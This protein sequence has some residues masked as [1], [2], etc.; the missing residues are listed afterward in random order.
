SPAVN[1]VAAAGDVNRVTAVGRALREV[2]WLAADGIREIVA[3]TR[4]LIVRGEHRRAHGRR[5]CD[6]APDLVV[7]GASVQRVRAVVTGNKVVPRAA[8]DLV[9]I[10]SR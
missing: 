7:S 10:R 5:I 9:T 4:K 3:R 8:V 6:V 2:A 1:L